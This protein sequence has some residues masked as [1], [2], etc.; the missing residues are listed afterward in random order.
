M[1]PPSTPRIWTIIKRILVIAVF[2]FVI[3]VLLHRVSRLL[4]RNP[5]PAG[6]A[7]GLVQGALMPMSLPNLVAGDNVTIYAQNNTGLSYKLGYTFGV[8]GC[9]AAFFGF[10]FWRLSR[11]RRQS[12][13]RIPQPKETQNF[14]L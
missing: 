9:G 13:G 11:W 7:R 4:E 5:H 6:F 12:N 3:G 10:L 8:N 14:E 1:N 2:A